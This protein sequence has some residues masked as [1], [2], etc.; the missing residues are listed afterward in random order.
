MIVIAV[1]VDNS[2]HILQLD[3]E[4]IILVGTHNYA[5]NLLTPAHFSGQVPLPCI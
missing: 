1:H 2:I 3:Q 5:L 4:N